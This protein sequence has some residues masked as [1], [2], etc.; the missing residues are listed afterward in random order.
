VRWL[1]DLARDHR[2][3]GWVLFPAADPEAKLVAS[4]HAELSAVYR[5][6]TPPW[7]I[8]RWAFDKR[9]TNECA[10]SAGIAVPWTHYPRNRREVA[11][12]DC[13]FP[14]IL[15][16]SVRDR[17]NAFTNAKAWRVD[18]RDALLARYEQAAALVGDQAVMLQELI[19]GRGEAQFSHAALWDRGK[20]LASLVAQRARQFPI[21]FGY[22]STYV[23]TIERAE[24]A[25]AA[26][27][28]MRAIEYSG[29]A[30][31]EFKY[32]HRDRAYKILDV[33]ARAWT[34]IALGQIAGTDFPYLQW[35]ATMGE[36]VPAVEAKPGAAWMHLSRDFV[37]ACQEMSLGALSPGAYLKSFSDPLTFAAFAGDDPL[38]GA[39]DLPLVAW[40]IAGRRLSGLKR[41]LEGAGGAVFEAPVSRD[42]PK[43][44][45]GA[46]RRLG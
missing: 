29:I 13:R 3:A 40:R 21:D 42:P 38:P 28:F 44:G 32:D 25:D 20:P 34:W 24:V 9:L 23:R 31:I 43:G 17:K 36:P 39:V 22:T 37:A 45:D 35:L 30:E 1:L 27:R 5:V 41:T 2:L 10:E 18:D 7:E 19:P 12:L 6:T 16:P 15:K 4:K 11:Q 14:L 33:N 8:A 46:P 26:E